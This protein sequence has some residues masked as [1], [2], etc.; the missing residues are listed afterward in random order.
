[1]I[2]NHFYTRY[3]IAL[4]MQE[5]NL[6]KIEDITSSMLSSLIQTCLDHFR[7]RPTSFEEND[8]A[9]FQFVSE[10]FLLDNTKYISS[11][12]HEGFFLSPN[13]ITT[14]K[15]SKNSWN[16]LVKI[17]GKL[18][19]DNRFDKSESA[20]MSIIPI[21]AKFNNGRISQSPPKVTF[22]EACLCMIVTSTPY[23]PALHTREKN[24]ISQQQ[25]SRIWRFPIFKN[26]LRCSK[27]CKDHK[28][29]I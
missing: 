14:D 19:A 2:S 11:H 4:L 20:T 6:A 8:R 5:N 16:A 3:G 27:K 22:I 1:M 17:K 26:S 25:L 29:E 24:L 18:D 12:C 7:L 10:K 28:R 23:K 21:T 15:Q 13:I 9:K